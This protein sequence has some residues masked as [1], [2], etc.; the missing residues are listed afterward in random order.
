MP[1]RQR[2]DGSGLALSRPAAPQP[3]REFVLAMSTDANL[4]LLNLSA[5]RE[6]S[7]PLCRRAVRSDPVENLDRAVSEKEVG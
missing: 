7:D 2:G 6:Y 4:L 3:L 5:L 1:R